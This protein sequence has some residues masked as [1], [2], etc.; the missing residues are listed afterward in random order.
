[1]E[2]NEAVEDEAAE[3]LIGVIRSSDAKRAKKAKRRPKK[4]SFLGVPPTNYAGRC[5]DPKAVTFDFLNTDPIRTPRL[6]LP[7]S[8]NATVPRW[9]KA[10]NLFGLF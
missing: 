8:E 1:M 4:E 7:N 2:E 3:N 6:V 5:P 10:Y 9:D